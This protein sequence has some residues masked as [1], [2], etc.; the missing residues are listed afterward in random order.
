MSRGYGQ[1]WKYSLF[2]NLSLYYIIAAHIYIPSLAGVSAEV[3]EANWETVACSMSM[4][5][6]HSDGGNTLEDMC[7]TKAYT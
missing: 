2:S 1:A 3:R 5:S 6:V 7:A 4:S